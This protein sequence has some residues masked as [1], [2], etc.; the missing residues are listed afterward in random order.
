MSRS[1][2]L[3]VSMLGL[4]VLALTLTSAVPAGAQA[5]GHGPAKCVK[6]KADGYP[7]KDID[8]LAHVPLTAMEGGGVA[9]VMG[10]V[11]PET[12]KEYAVVG[13]AGGVRFFDVSKPTKPVY[14]G[15]VLGKP[16]VALPWQELE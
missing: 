1:R 16:E 11:D 15:R 7:C 12:K 3:I 2:A 9:D 6:G 14:M 10:W 4:L 8:L 13:G 5:T